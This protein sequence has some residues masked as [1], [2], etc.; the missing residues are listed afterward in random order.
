ML[1]HHIK[2]V[3]LVN[4]NTQV[5]FRMCILSLILVISGCAGQQITSKSSVFEYL[6]PGEQ[7]SV[8]QPSIPTLNIPLSVG[9]AFV[10]E[11]EIKSRFYS[12]WAHT[13]KK[14]QTL[15]AVS[16]LELLENV[17][18]HFRQYSYIKNIE[19]IPPEYLVAGGS[20]ANLDQI[21][22][23]YQVDVMALVSYDQVQFTDEG[24][25]SLTYWTLVGAYVIKAE[26]NDTSTMIDTAVYDIAS[27]KMLFRA[28]GASKIEG[29]S[30][31]INISES[32]RE[33]SLKGFQDASEQMIENLDIQLAK[34]KE[35]IEEDQSDVKLNYDE[36]FD[37]KGGSI[38]FIE[39]LLLMGI[40]LIVIVKG[41]YRGR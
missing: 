15:T 41:I 16:K 1:E 20:F 31:L 22:T 4:A 27:R 14:G 19:V 3:S 33:D 5:I 28:P 25:A 13:F 39:F 29:S 2:E 21:K 26:K 7:N 24:L 35:K 17:A 30:T 36:S 38:G 9:I 10:P 8:I 32:L 18:E 37:R 6:Y 34:F 11:S 40:A 23:M 12:P